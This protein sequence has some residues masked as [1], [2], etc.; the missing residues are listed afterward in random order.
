MLRAEKEVKEENA[1]DQD[2]NL[3]QYSETKK[4][5]DVIDDDSDNYCHINYTDK[6]NEMDKEGTSREKENDDSDRDEGMAFLA[7]K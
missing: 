7:S 4:K 3:E 6:D 2:E 1:L 5:I